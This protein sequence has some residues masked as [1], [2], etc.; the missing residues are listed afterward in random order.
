MKKS[1]IVL[2]SISIF[3]GFI[4]IWYVMQYFRTGHLWAYINPPSF[5][6]IASEPESFFDGLNSYQNVE[7]T[8]ANFSKKGYS[9]ELNE[10]NNYG[11]FKGRKFVATIFTIN[12]YKVDKKNFALKLTY[13]NNRLAQ[14]AIC[15]QSNADDIIDFSKQEIKINVN[16]SSPVVRNNLIAQYAYDKN[17][18]VYFDDIRLAEESSLWTDLTQ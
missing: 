8:K 11:E 3:A 17:H 6:E 4:C 7:M 16:Q 18:C 14:V 12:N 13:Y 9:L 2:L 10:A 15:S 5:K 1:R